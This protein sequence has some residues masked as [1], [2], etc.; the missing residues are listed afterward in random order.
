MRTLALVL[1]FGLAGCAETT[2]SSGPAAMNPPSIGAQ[3]ISPD[4][5]PAL[6]RHEVRMQHA[7]REP[8]TRTFEMR[9]VEFDCA[10]CRR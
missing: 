7:T 3:P 8:M 10:R 5:G 1:F 4:P 2:V 6:D 9:H